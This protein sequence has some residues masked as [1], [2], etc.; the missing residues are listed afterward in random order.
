MSTFTGHGTLRR[1]QDL[2]QS[3]F[4][5]GAVNV[6]DYERW[7]S[8]LGGGALAAFGLSRGTLGGF[9]MAALGGC[10]AY[11]GATGHCPMYQSLGV[12]TSEQQRPPRTSIPAG[13]GVK[14]ETSITI[15]RPR[16]EL[17]RFWRNFE[18]LPRFMRHLESVTTHGDRRSH[19]AAKGPFGMPVDWEAELITERAN[20]LMG[21]RSLPGSAVDTAG[22]VHFISAPGGRVTLVRVVLKYDPPAGKF[23]AALADLFGESP[24]RQI[25]EDLQ[26]F[27]Q[28]MEAG[29]GTTASRIG[30]TQTQTTSGLGHK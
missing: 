24:E 13:H 15:N 19:W 10:L 11:R 7:A 1:F 30:T 4:Q 25:N 21:W 5:R 22:S 29:E 8:L 9:A 2:A 16:E 6:G 20:E 12:N 28:M 27:K 17:F 3:T 26:H 14:V 23:G 18:N